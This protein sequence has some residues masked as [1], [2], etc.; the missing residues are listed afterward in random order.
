MLNIFA[1]ADN[2]YV[3]SLMR[4]L[5]TLEERETSTIIEGG[6]S[7]SKQKQ[8][9]PERVVLLKGNKLRMI[10]LFLNH[11]MIKFIFYRGVKV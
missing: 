9:D 2:K 11:L 8:L 10:F 4:F 1:S 7:R 5:F 6:K 3:T